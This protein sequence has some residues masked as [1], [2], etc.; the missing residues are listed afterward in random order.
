[1][2]TEKLIFILPSRPEAI[3]MVRDCLGRL[4]KL[5]GFT[6]QE[7]EDLKLAVNEAYANTIKH[8]YGG[9]QSKKVVLKLLYQPGRVQ[10]RVRNFG[11][12][13]RMEDLKSRALDSLDDHGLGL[14]LMEKFMS[15]L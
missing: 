5:A 4:A 12:K 3:G 1:M 8:A 9:D 10:V 14:F 11:S 6:S 13:P 15:F 7:D 2:F